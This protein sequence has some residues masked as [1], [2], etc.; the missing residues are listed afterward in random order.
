MTNNGFLKDFTK[1]FVSL[2][3]T[4]LFFNHANAWSQDK[5]P[6]II[7]I[8][9]DDQ[10]A[11]TVGA[12]GNNEAITPNLDKLAED[13]AYLSNMFVTTPVSS[14]ARAG[15][16]TSKYASEVNIPDFIVVPSHKLH[17]PEKGRVGLAP[18][19]VTFVELLR[20]AGYRTGLVGKW[21]LGDWTRDASRTFHP[22]N[23]GFEHFVGITGG[24]TATADAA[25]E[26]D[27]VITKQK[28]FTD[29]I[30]TRRALK[31]IRDNKND[32]FL[33][34]VMY[35]SPHTPWRPAPRADRAVY[36]GKDLTISHM[37]YP[38]LDTVRVK[39]MM[40]DYMVNVATVDRN[41]G[42]ILKELERLGL[43]DSTIVIF[44]S[45]NGFNMGHNGIWHKGNGLWATKT[46]PPSTENIDGK[47]RPNLYDNSLKVPGIIRWPGVVSP[48]LHV[49]N[50]VSNLDWYPTI[51]QMA[52][53]GTE[54]APQGIR[55]KSIVP[56]LKEEESN[57]WD[58][59]IYTEYSM[60]NYCTALMRSYRT[61][62]WKLVR[63]FL[64]PERDELY[65]LRND[66]GERN[67]LISSK[68]KEIITA[69]EQLDRK[70][71]RK[72]EEIND[73]LLK[74]VRKKDFTDYLNSIH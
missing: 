31:Y 34:C 21:H 45:D 29:N 23:Y 47:Y 6:N 55:G 50:T 54:N 24:G 48:G 73:P 11:W 2:Q 8:C 61:P 66:P 49:S 74:S 69:I 5:K 35:R 20:N 68:N 39:R 4:A 64:N 59:D 52:G 65:D 32:P 58:N 53:V 28:G 7:F 43:F 63:D 30:L 33:L 71:L 10:A 46:M 57:K 56:L 1:V 37:D 14:P 42:D 27:G 22:T 44:T 70:L 38:D 51:L 9:T 17:T 13:G 62:E 72:M 26:E 67:N 3:C 19:E 12:S 15:I 16:F 41:V 60:I 18:D 25:I 36:A 40:E